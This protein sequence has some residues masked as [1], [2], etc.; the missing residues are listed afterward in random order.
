[1]IDNPKPDLE[2]V[3]G[4]V[5]Q[6]ARGLQAFHRLEMLHQDLRPDNIMIDKTGTVKIID[7]GSTRVAGVVEAVA[8]DQSG[9]H[10][11]HRAVHRAGIFPGGGRLAALRPVLARAS[12]PTRC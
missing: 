3:R 6:I 8:I 7:F 1:M 2:T 12:S 5:E 4:I 9:R 10:P 11:G